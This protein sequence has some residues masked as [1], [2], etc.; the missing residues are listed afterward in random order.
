MKSYINLT[1]EELPYYKGK[2]KGI[3]N[4]SFGNSK[5]F[6]KGYNYGIS[7]GKGYDD[8]NTNGISYGKGYDDSNTNCIS[9]G[10]GYDDSNTNG[11]SFGKGYNTNGIS[12]GK[13]YDDSNTNGKS[14]GKG[15]NTNGK[16]FGKGYNTNGKSFGKGYNTNGKSFGKGYN[17]NGK[18][19]GKGYN[20][21]SS[22]KGY[23]ENSS[24]KGYVNDK[25]QLNL[26][27]YHQ[28]H[29]DYS[30][31]SIDIPDNIKN[32]IEFKEFIFNIILSKYIYEADIDI[33]NKVVV[34]NI[35]QKKNVQTHFYKSNS[36]TEISQIICESYKYK[37]GM[38]VYTLTAEELSKR[39][40]KDISIFNTDSLYI[41]CGMW[42]RINEI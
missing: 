17:T 29:I 35:L 32:Y 5:F 19:F 39:T 2:G 8:S 33:D 22:G 10:K 34:L 40:N 30:G 14:F 18:S 26:D 11:K 9:Y 25:K 27:I 4:M 21:N 7:Y 16:S 38:C 37:Y 6:G 15:Y 42:K 12:Y 36:C 20:D 13:G 23:N 1:N 3:Y 31:I 28:D 24:G 41:I